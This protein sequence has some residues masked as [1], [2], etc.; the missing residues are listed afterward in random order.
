MRPSIITLALLLI[1]TS[2][3]D[4]DD[5]LAV[6]A[7]QQIES[8]AGVCPRCRIAIH[9]H[10]RSLRV[11]ANNGWTATL[12][13]QDSGSATLAGGVG[14]W[15]D[16]AGIM[17]GK[18]FDVHFAVKGERLYMTMLVDIGNGS[19]HAVHAVFGRPWFG[20]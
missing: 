9:R 14:S 10:G 12:V 6:G 11:T 16:R 2:S 7:W 5:A 18:R 4:A 15:S 13:A 1:W 19:R 17:A 20:V 8:D 3:A